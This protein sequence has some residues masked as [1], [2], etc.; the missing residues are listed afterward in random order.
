[1]NMRDVNVLNDI[2]DNKQQN[3]FLKYLE[4]LKDVKFTEGTN[5]SQGF[6]IED[7]LNG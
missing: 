3:N 4:N 6:R 1:M 5:V 7:S 2:T